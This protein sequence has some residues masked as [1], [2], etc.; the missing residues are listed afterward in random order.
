MSKK[1]IIGKI[2]KN[3]QGLEFVILEKSTNKASH[4]G[5]KYKV[6][7]IESGYEV[8]VDKSGIVKR[9]VKDKLAK[10]VYGIGMV[11]DINTAKFYKEYHMWASMLSRCYNKNAENYIN[12]GKA[13]ITVCEK[14]HLFTNFLEDI[15][16]ID[17]YDKAMYKKGLLVLDKDIKQLNKSYTERIYSLET[18]TFVTISENN[19]YRE[20]K[21]CF[22]AIEPNGY[23]HYEKGVKEFCEKHP[24]FIRSGVSGCLTK[25]EKYKTHRGWKFTKISQDQYIKGINSNYIKIFHKEDSIFNIKSL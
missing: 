11:G 6:K 19:K 25:P 5:Y 21:L 20:S 16:K 2:F 13:G 1:N 23:I 17:G 7:F 18:C 8:E 3:T 4:G 12:Y 9:M 10:S 14:W 22:K 24:G 15:P